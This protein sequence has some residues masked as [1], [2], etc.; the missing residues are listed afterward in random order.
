VNKTLAAVFDPRANGLNFVR[1]V[2]AGSVIVCH[3][4]ALSG[5]EIAWAPLRRIV[6]D[7]GV[8]GFFAIS[9]FLI[10]SSWMR[11]PDWRRYLRARVLRI[12]PA[13][14]MCLIVTAFVIAPLATGVLGPDNFGYVLRNS[15]LLIVQH[16]IAGTPS[17]VPYEGAWN[18]SLWTLACEFL[19]Y[20]GVLFL[21]LTKLLRFR[22]TL[23]VLFLIALAASYA[24]AVGVIENPVIAQGSRLGL[25][26]MAGALVWQHQHRIPVRGGTVALAIAL[27]AVASFLPSYQILAALPLAYLVLVS[28]A[29]IRTEK[30]RLSNDISYG[31][32]IYAFPLQQVLAIAGAYHLGIAAY[33]AMTA[34]ATVP[35]AAM[36][37]FFVEKPIM[38]LNKKSLP[39][40]SPAANERP[41]VDA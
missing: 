10:V 30:L 34:L 41:A 16:D 24:T 35:V 8:D 15:A 40:W 6:A 20:L 21:G 38:R 25:M 9:G 1:L 33:S 28:G 2:L 31:V 19:C 4:Y 12:M 13:F 29:L 14:W 23:P 5:D 26:F 39:A 27:V 3:A 7:V 37:W 22:A 11:T 17:G 36:S 32:Y 18:G